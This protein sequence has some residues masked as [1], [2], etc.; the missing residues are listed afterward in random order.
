MCIQNTTPYRQQRQHWLS[1]QA[2]AWSGSPVVTIGPTMFLES[3]S[4]LAGPTVRDRG[5]IELL[6]GQPGGATAEPAK[7]G[8]IE[9]AR[10]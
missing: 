5:R 7:C 6:L 10:S 3:F 2:L 9:R 8:R 4:S 1:E